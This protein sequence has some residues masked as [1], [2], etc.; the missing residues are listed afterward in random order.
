MPLI[1]NPQFYS[2][3]LEIQAILPTH[4]LVILKRFLKSR[5]KIVDFLLVTYFGT[6]VIFFVTVS[7]LSLQLGLLF[8]KKILNSK[9]IM[10]NIKS[11]DVENW[12]ENVATRVKTHSKL[13]RQIFQK[14]TI[15]RCSLSGNLAEVSFTASAKTVQLSALLSLAPIAVFF[16]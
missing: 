13:L 9:N 8:I 6:W 15:V 12:N 2:K 16:G 1:K 7:I 14:P 5:D 4:E 3:Q 11:Q 10:L